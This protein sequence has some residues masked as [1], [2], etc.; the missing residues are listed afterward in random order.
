MIRDQIFDVMRPIILSV[1]GV[2]ECILANSNAPSPSGEYC[3]V[4]P[5]LGIEERG[6]ANVLMKTSLTPES[7]DTDVQAQLITECSLNFYRG[8]SRSRA[9]RM[10]QAN[11]IPSVSAALFNANLG[12]NRTGPINDLTALQSADW[13]SRAQISIYL[14]FTTTLP[15]TVNSIETVEYELQNSEGDI[16]ETGEVTTT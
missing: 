2:P 15:E 5:F 8:D 1:T 16:L 6:Q 9:Q 14:M 13:E 4:E 12:W 10:K 3:S 7:V 11:K